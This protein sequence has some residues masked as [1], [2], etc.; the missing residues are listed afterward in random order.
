MPVLLNSTSLERRSDKLNLCQAGGVPPPFFSAYRFSCNKF[1]CDR[2][3][4]KTLRLLAYIH[5]KHF[6]KF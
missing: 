5:N 1:F 4:F 3:A 6:G 2:C